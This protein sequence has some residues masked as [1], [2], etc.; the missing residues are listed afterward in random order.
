M[1][2]LAEHWADFVVDMVCSDGG[3]VCQLRKFMQGQT[4]VVP[5]EIWEKGECLSFE[6]LDYTERNKMRQLMRNYYNQESLTEAHD[7]LFS[8]LDGK[9]YQTSVA[10]STIGG[11]KRGDSQGHCMR[12]VVVTHFTKSVSKEGEFLTVDIMYRSTELIKKFGADL[13]FLNKF[14]VPEIIK[15]IDIPIRE[16]R[17]YFSNLFVSS[18]FL[19]ILYYMKDPVQILEKIRSTDAEFFKR[20]VTQNRTFLQKEYGHFSYRTRREMHHLALTLME[21]GVIDRNKLTA[22]VD[23]VGAGLPDLNEEDEDDE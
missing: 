19:P 23:K 14:L 17:F 16:V 10:A 9:K 7:K 1:K 15:G 11:A 13:I 22:Y 5:G 6:Q 12:S 8:R 3:Y 18:L 2:T 21:Q 4:W 20:C